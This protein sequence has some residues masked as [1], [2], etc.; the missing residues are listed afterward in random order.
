MP[1][2]EAFKKINRLAASLIELRR[3]GD[4]GFC[5]YI[6]TDASRTLE[7][8]SAAEE[9]RRKVL[10]G[11]YGENLTAEQFEDLSSQEREEEFSSAWPKVPSGIRSGLVRDL[12]HNLSSTEG[13]SYL[14]AILKTGCFSLVITSNTDTLIE[15]ALVKE[16]VPR[17]QWDSMVNGL[18][19]SE[20]IRDGL[21]KRG[22]RF[23]ILKLCGEVRSRNYSVTGREINASIQPL[24]ATIA[25]YLSQPMVVTGYSVI[26]DN[27]IKAFPA[28]REIVYHIGTDPPPGDWQFYRHFIQDKRV[29]ILDDDLTFNSFCN[30]LA[31]RLDVIKNVEAYGRPVTPSVVENI[32]ADADESE[33]LVELIDNE[34]REKLEQP[35]PAPDQ[36]EPLVVLTDTLTS[37]TIRFDNSELLSFAVKGKFSYES[38]RAVT[39]PVDVDELNT[40]MSDL[41]RDI[42]AYY[43]LNDEGGRNTWRRHAKR[44]G[45]HLYDSLMRSNEDLSKQLEVARRTMR[46]PEILN[47]NFV[48]PR[49]HLG[50]PY[51]LLHDNSVPLVVRYPLSRQISGIPLQKPQ[52]FDSFMRVTQKEGKPLRVLLIASDTGKLS[53][54]KEVTSLGQVFQQEWQGK[55]DIK[56]LTTND[57]SMSEVEKVLKHSPYHIIHFA[58]HA[59]FD[60]EKPENSGLFVFKDKNRR[61]GAGILPARHIAQLLRDSD[62]M[63]CYLS[64][65][66]GA[67]VGSAQGLR[68][69]DYLGVMDAVTQAGVPYVL[70]YRWY[71]TDGGSRRFAGLYYE[72]LLSD[73]TTPE[74]AA[75]HARSQLYGTDGNDETWTSPILV[76]QNVE[77]LRFKVRYA[78]YSP[79]K[80]QRRKGSPAKRGSALRLCSFA[81][82]IF[83]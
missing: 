40:V 72:K 75:L 41:G 59:Q 69:E 28:P 57:A 2:E 63:F 58:G 82:D 32:R 33:F 4:P 30:V 51:E 78:G 16:D 64:C 83:T 65:C 60:F 70:G 62:T 80:A 9:L 68:D 14:A 79:A 21:L 74:L 50:M 22:N 13:Y 45:R 3:G 43:R 25:P 19:S 38:E 48:G 20:V 27:I 81:G 8:V 10:C 6:G 15:D 5:L 12:T 7:G 24:I 52:S 76:A 49:N 47:L 73:R 36:E 35:A 54:D 46:Q 23:I 1:R 53:A 55:S 61:G 17:S 66:V 77:S 34:K 71:V 44:E 37:F 29:D 26:D 18:D 11:E 42:A 39:W 67:M 31:R 56:V